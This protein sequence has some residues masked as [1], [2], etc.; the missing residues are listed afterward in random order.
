MNL[1]TSKSASNFARPSTHALPLGSHF[2]NSNISSCCLAAVCPLTCLNSS[3]LRCFTVHTST[4]PRL[5]SSHSCTLHL[6]SD[7]ETD[8]LGGRTY[9][10][11]R[12]RL[13]E[14]LRHLRPLHPLQR[15]LYLASCWRISRKPWECAALPRPHPTAHPTPFRRPFTS[16]CNPLPPNSVPSPL[17]L[18]IACRLSDATASHAPEANSSQ[19]LLIASATIL[20]FS[21]IVVRS[22]R[23][24][25]R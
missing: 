25:L 2:F 3:I 13:L 15:P 11:G 9:H 5:S 6:V 4:S 20:H 14:N 8:T 21:A 12:Y 24:T 7:T 16:P 22:V 19:G 1:C 10:T 18:T 17:L 23:C